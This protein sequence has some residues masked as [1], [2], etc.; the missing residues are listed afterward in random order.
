M[1]RV[2]FLLLLFTSSLFCNI[3]SA[4]EKFYFAKKG[5]YIV[6]EQQNIYSF[7]TILEKKEHQL[8]LE[9]ITL[10]V[11]QKKK[12]ES[13]AN[14][15]QK[16]AHGQTSHILYEID[17]DQALLKRAYSLSQKAYLKPEALLPQLLSLPLKKLKPHERKKIGPTPP[18]DQIDT[19]KIWN[20]PLFRL[21]K[22]VQNPCFE[23]YSARWP[24]DETPLSQ[25]KINLY[26]DL[27]RVDFPFPCWIEISDGSNTFKIRGIDTGDQ[28]PLSPAC[29]PPL[30]PEFK[31]GI[32]E[33]ENQ[34]ILTTTPLDKSLNFYLFAIDLSSSLR[35][36]HAIA[37]TKSESQIFI[38]KLLISRLF[39]KG[40]RYQWF[41]MIEG[42][43]E[44][45]IDHPQ[46]YFY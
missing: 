2:F 32:E 43:G 30:P 35:K 9:E 23:A 12:K 39:T 24:R 20:P 21:G 11:S 14:W 4:K 22:K 28:L 6:T 7:L 3:H 38:E 42:Q 16:G 1:K 25:K 44:L 19:R 29:F 8:I 31:P 36:T 34:I 37:F 5:Q 41:L 45:S 18:C 10:P 13:W 33:D 40:H 46:N 26:F 17:I 15:Y 27:K